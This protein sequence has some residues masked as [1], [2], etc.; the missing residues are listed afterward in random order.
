MY[1]RIE[2]QK[3][4]SSRAIA[5]SV[6]QKKNNGEQGVGFIDNRLQ[7]TIQRIKGKK[8]SNNVKQVSTIIQLCKDKWKTNSLEKKI[9][10]EQKNS[11]NQNLVYTAHH[12]LPKEKLTDAYQKLPIK[13]Q[14]DIGLKLMGVKKP[15]TKKEI[16]SLPFNLTL[17]PKPE[18]RSD[19]P[20]DSFDPNY[21]TGAMTPR[22]KA[23]SDAWNQTKN[24]I[25]ETKLVSAL[26]NAFKIHQKDPKIDRSNWTMKDGKYERDGK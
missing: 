24:E 25:D 2:K 16:K 22:S 11:K 6:G 14:E 1:T 3:E 8:I 5:N 19:D 18:E 21:K 7:N 23:L 4:N 12:I 9:K 15:L 10:L 13:D 26:E 20:K 17:G